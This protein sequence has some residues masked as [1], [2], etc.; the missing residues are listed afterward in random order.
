MS[1][2]T[3][4]PLS[5]SGFT[6]IELITSLSIASILLAIGIPSFQILTQ[7]NRMTGAINTITSHLNLARSEAVKRG[8]DV[9]LCPSDDG[10]DCKSTMI[11]D[12]EIIM[13]T[14]INKNRHL[15]PEEEL[16]RHINLNPE[17]IR[18]TTTIGRKKAVYDFRGFSMG[19]NVSFTFC[20]T[21]DK[22]D[23]K[24]VIVSNSG[25]ARISDTKA[26]GTELDCI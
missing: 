18:I 9:V 20:D 2:P 4:L 19:Y 14:D 17:S 16:I 6:L 3:A 22:T 1:K 15:D 7:S 12:K 10:L 5:Y 21:F 25:R 13:F 11:W 23:P 8:I 26:D 24:A